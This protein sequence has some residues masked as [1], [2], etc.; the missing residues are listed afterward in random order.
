MEKQVAGISTDN[1]STKSSAR[2]ITEAERMIEDY[3]TRCGY[4]AEKGISDASQAE[5]LQRRRKE[6]YHNISSLLERYRSL[7]RTYC[8]FKQE[9]AS[10]VMETSTGKPVKELDLFDQL[11]KHLDLLSVTE[12]RKFQKRYAPHITAGRKIGVALKALHFG[13]RVLEAESPTLHQIINMVY[14][15]GSEKPSVRHVAETL[16]YM[17]CNSYYKKLD[18]AKRRLTELVFGF[19]SNKEELLSILIYLRQQAE[20]EDFP[21]YE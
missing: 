20:D 10:E 7:Y 4:V 14:I 15:E 21:Y 18:Q 8:V 13:L 11:S 6:N 1:L 19:A 3:L 2:H 17:S 5:A 16:G 12:E 9:F